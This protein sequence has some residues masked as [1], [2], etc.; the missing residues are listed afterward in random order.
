MDIIHPFTLILLKVLINQKKMSFLIF[1]N[2]PN[3]PNLKNFLDIFKNKVSKKQHNH[4]DI[5]K[6]KQKKN[7]QCSPWA[8][9]TELNSILSLL[10]FLHR[11]AAAERQCNRINLFSLADTHKLIQKNESILL[12][13]F[14]F[15][16][17]EETRQTF[18]RRWRNNYRVLIYLLPK[19]RLGE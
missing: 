13:S 9:W 11:N 1:K 19:L 8:I 4:L 3:Y 5:N 2:N 14:Y 6:G 16:W 18:I 17:I 7:E 15:R 10:F 12:T